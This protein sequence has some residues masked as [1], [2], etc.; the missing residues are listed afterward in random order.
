LLLAEFQH[1]DDGLMTA[2][3]CQ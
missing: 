3:C 1:S 2:T